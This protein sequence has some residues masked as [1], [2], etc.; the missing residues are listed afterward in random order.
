MIV[1]VYKQT[2]TTARLAKKNKSTDFIFVSPSRSYRLTV[3]TSGSHPDNP[4]SIPGE[5]TTKIAHLQ[6]W[7]FFVVFLL[8]EI[9]IRS[10]LF[11]A[12][13]FAATA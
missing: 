9:R 10:R 4:G 11:I 1:Y 7:A 8:A 12:I 5:I 13:Q 2:Y 3:R 6:R